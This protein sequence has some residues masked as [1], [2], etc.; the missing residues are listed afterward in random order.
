MRRAADLGGADPRETS[1]ADVLASQIPHGRKCDCD[2]CC[3]D[4]VESLMAPRYPDEE[5]TQA[6]LVDDLNRGDLSRAKSK[7]AKRRGRA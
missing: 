7:A 6:W 3:A 1:A 2:E 4:M 5:Y